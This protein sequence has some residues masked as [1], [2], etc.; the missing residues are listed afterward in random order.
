[1]NDHT[2]RPAPGHVSDD[3]IE[4]ALYRAMAERRISRRQLL[5]A[6]ARVGP[7]AA[8]APILAACSGASTPQPSVAPPPSAAPTTAASVAPPSATPSAAPTPVPSP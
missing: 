5:E 2:P 6:A 3:A 7:V 1:M 4:L 8:I